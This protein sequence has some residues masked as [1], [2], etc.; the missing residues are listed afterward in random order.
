MIVL[1]ESDSEDEDEVLDE[2]LSLGT[3]TE[4]WTGKNGISHRGKHC[5]ACP[6]RAL[7]TRIANLE[8][9]T[10]ASLRAQLCTRCVDDFTFAAICSGCEIVDEPEDLYC[11]QP[12][13]QAWKDAKAAREAAGTF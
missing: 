7:W 5:R 8:F 9:C 4:V 6:R 2:V 11:W 10:V 12:G 3:E 1:D 13:S